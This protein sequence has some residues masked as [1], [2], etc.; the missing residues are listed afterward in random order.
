MDLVTLSSLRMTNRYV[1]VAASHINI[2]IEAERNM[3]EFY[4]FFKQSCGNLFRTILPT[5]FHLVI[6]NENTFI[7]LYIS[8]ILLLGI[9]NYIYYIIPILYYIILY[10]QLSLQTASDVLMAESGC[11]LDDPSSSTFRHLVLKGDWTGA[12]NGKIWQAKLIL[13]KFTYQ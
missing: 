9:N 1:E 6:T 3:L 5:C 12:V 7:I 4:L 13:P 11:R 2:P 10:Y 8:Y